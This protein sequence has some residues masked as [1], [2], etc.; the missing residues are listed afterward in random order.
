ML[1]HIDIYVKDLEKQSNFWSWFLGEL[2]YQEFQ[3]WE[4]GISWKKADFYYVLSIG[5]QELIQAPYQKGGIGLNHIAFGTEK[6]ATV[7]RLKEEIQAH[8]GKVLYAEDYPYA[9]GPDHYALYFNDPEGMKM[10][11]VAME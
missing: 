7:D 8:G 11:L 6:R 9:G 10:E 1:H 2:G 4:T 5:D 3:K